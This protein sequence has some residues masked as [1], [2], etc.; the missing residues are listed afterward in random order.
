[1]TM[2]ISISTCAQSSSM[3]VVDSFGA[4]I[5]RILQHRNTNSQVV[6]PVDANTFRIP[7]I[8]LLAALDSGPTA[9]RE[10]RGLLR[11]L[12]RLVV[13]AYRR[14][15]VGSDHGPHGCRVHCEPVQAARPQGHDDDV[16]RGQALPKRRHRAANGWTAIAAQSAWTGADRRTTVL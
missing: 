5:G 4:A 6:G 10:D 16:L 8:S 1:M 2:A 9:R 13:S 12:N 7:R 3:F 14:S 11:A 15:S